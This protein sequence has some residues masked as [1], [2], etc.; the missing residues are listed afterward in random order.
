MKSARR[1][2]ISSEPGMAGWMLWSS[3]GA[4]SWKRGVVRSTGQVVAC[5]TLENTVM[6]GLITKKSL[7]IARKREKVNYL[8]DEEKLPTSRVKSSPS[9]RQ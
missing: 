1:P 6:K 3:D 4:I 8:V 5:L 7:T 9:N 2:T